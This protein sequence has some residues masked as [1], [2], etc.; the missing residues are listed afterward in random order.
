MQPGDRDHDGILDDEDTLD[1]S[2]PPVPGKSVVVRVVSGTVFIKYPAGQAP[3]AVGP[4]AGF[5]P[6]KGA[7][8]MPIGSQL[9]TANGRVALTSAADTGGKKTQTSRLLPGH[10]PGQA[11]GAQEEAQEAQGA[12]HRS[13]A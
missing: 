10:L 4:A 1:G 12:D 11:D 3:R 2:K 8:N 9:D 13:G 5:V 7:A 6:L